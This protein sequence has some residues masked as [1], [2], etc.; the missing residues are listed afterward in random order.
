MKSTISCTN[1]FASRAVLPNDWEGHNI[2]LSDSK[3]YYL[4]QGEII[5]EALGETIV[6]K[7]GDLFLIPAHTPH[8]FRLTEQAYAEKF[9]CHF[10]L[11]RGSSDFF[12]NYSIPTVLHV[13][14]RAVVNHLFRELV[15]SSQ[16]PTAQQELTATSAICRLVDYYFKNTDV[17][18]RQIADDRIHG[19][20]AYIKE[21]Y[22]EDLTLEHLA[23]YANYSPNHL[24]KRFKDITGYPPMR[25]L[26]N[27]RIEQAKHL[28]QSTN[29]PVSRIM[30]QTGFTNA[31]YFSKSFKKMMGYSPQKF[32]KL[33]RSPSSK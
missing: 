18:E 15:N 13:K 20:I 3:F 10:E 33:Y 25:Y 16:L 24:G 29:Y 17:I 32:R 21:H 9:W 4:E 7:P 28:L 6:G 2:T 22:A 12:Q 14:D 27:V 5:V 26:N 31:A 23:R 8:S 11:K 30:T 19:V 1:R